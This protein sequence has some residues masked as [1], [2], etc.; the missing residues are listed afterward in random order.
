VGPVRRRP[1][2][3]SPRAPV[4]AWSSRCRRTV[5][6][7][8]RCRRCCGVGSLRPVSTGAPRFSA[9]PPH[10]T[11]LCRQALHRPRREF[12]PPGEFFTV[13]AAAWF[14]PRA[15]PSPPSPAAAVGQRR[16][17]RQ[18]G[19]P[20]LRPQ[21]DCGSRTASAL[22]TRAALFSEPQPT[23][24]AAAPSLCPVRIETV[25]IVSIAG[26]AERSHSQHRQ[27]TVSRLGR[28]RRR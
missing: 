22:R 28:C 18:S 12:L 16:R 6:P 8:R 13:R 17:K 24:A 19:T 25:L 1:A 4:P 20:G 3:A 21:V 23:K 7:P 5:T 9:C 10:S 14:W 27:L 11:V 15:P 2:A 26:L